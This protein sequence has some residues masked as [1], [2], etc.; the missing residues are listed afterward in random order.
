MVT[1]LALR[2][3]AVR[4]VE[5]V[6][7]ASVVLFAARLLVP[8][9]PTPF[10]GHGERFAAMAAD[11]FAFDGA[12][13]QRVLWPL[14][15]HVAG[16]F[17]ISATAFSQVCSGVLL[18]TV[19]AFA[20]SR[21]AKRLDALLVTVAVGASG[22]ILVYQR[23]AC[24]SDTL[25]LAGM[26]GA[27]AT[28]GTARWFW[29][30]VFVTALAHEMVF[31]FTPW[32]WCLRRQHGGGGLHDVAFFAGVFGV[33]GG[34]RA[35][36]ALAGGG[37]YGASYYFEHN[38]WVPYG[39]PALWALWALVVLVEFGPLLAFVGWAW[40][41]GEL[42]RGLG[43]RAG[44]W[45]FWLGVLSL[46]VLAYDVMRFATFAVVPFVVGAIAWLDGP[47]RRLPFV[48]AILAAV[49]LYPWLHPVP[50]QEGGWHFTVAAGHVRELMPRLMDRDPVESARVTWELAVRTWPIVLG[51]VGGFV[52]VLALAS[53]LAR[54][55][56]GQRA[57]CGL[58]DDRTG[59]SGRDARS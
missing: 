9:W 7:V 22:A 23:M 27:I 52:G 2:L 24:F 39:L 48:V 3:P 44:P 55:A 40:R 41:A 45:C 1:S 37:A 5:A 6:L 21:G 8:A 12:F 36:I 28:A 25:V 20:S 17:G 53:L 49:V 51:A 47:R 34:F 32:L 26:L 11:P 42:T 10:E 38:F 33:Y 30:L 29:P 50:S 18:A 43:G 4:L 57:V 14:L 54:L 59:W 56:A 58:G 46:M 15:A 19:H 35:L 31:F 13:P 16:W